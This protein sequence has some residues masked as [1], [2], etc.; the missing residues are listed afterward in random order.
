MNLI[1]IDTYAGRWQIEKYPLLFLSCF[2]CFLGA[3]L[4]RKTSSTFPSRDR[5]PADFDQIFTRHFAEANGVRLH[6]VIGGPAEGEMVVLLHGWPQTW[7]TWRNVMPALAAAGYRVA[8][9]DYRGAGESEKPQGGYDKATMAGDIRALVQQFGK[10]KINLVGRDI[11]LMVAYAYAAQWPDEVSKL[12]MLDVPIPASRAWNEARA[13]ADPGIWHFGLH[14]E[15]DIAEMLITGHEHA[16][17]LDFYKKR[18]HVP[19]ADEDIAVYARAYAAPGGLRAGFELY[20]AFPE[21]ERR[22]KEFMTKKLP[23]PVLALAGD[24]SVGQTE[25]ETAKELAS[26]VRGGV[27]S[28]VGHWLPDEAPE[29]LSKQLLAFFG[30]NAAGG[31]APR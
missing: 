12:V 18:M 17:I 21:D 2:Y 5:L 3:L 11:G 16:Y 13:K 10:S 30:Q 4:P 27:A 28:N 25:L 22:F 7:F 24:K 9:V 8:A 20:R 29:F 26:D 1:R 23:M 19:V 6:Y 14:Q 31:S 15:R